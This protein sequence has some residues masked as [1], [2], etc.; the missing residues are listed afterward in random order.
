MITAIFTAAAN[1][2][3]FS[4]EYKETYNNKILLS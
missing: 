1:I 3:M 2:S 4:F